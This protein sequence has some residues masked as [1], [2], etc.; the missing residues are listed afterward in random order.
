M[1]WR[2]AAIASAGLLVIAVPPAVRHLRELPPP[3]PPAIRLALTPPAGAELGAGDQILDAALSADD[4][5]LV[6]VATTDGIPRLWRRELATERA[7]P[8][9]GTD[10]AAMP[11]WK[12]TGRVVSFFA[13]GRLRQISLPSG[14]V[15]DLADAP[16]P[17]GAAWL[18]DGSLLFVPDDRGAVRHLHDG[19]VTDATRLRAGER[20]HGFPA[21]ANEGGFTYVATLSTGR[22][23]VRLVADGVERDLTETSSHAQLIGAHLVHVRDGTLIARRFDPERGALDTRSTALAFNVGVASNGQGFFA[24]SPRV[25]AWAAAAPRE[26]ELVWFDFDGRRRGT[27]GEPAD[28]WQIRLSPTDR[29]VAITLLH[30]LLRTLDIFV[31]PL[32]RTAP[33]EQLTLALAAD[34]DPVWSP[35]GDRVLFRSLPRGHP[36]LFARRVHAPESDAEAVFRSELDETPSDWRGGTV[37]FHAPGGAGLEVWALDI[38]RGTRT[39]ATRRGFSTF[40]ARWSP[41]GGR[42]A[43]ASDEGGRPDIYVEPWPPT[44]QRTRVSYAGGTRPEWGRDGRSLFFL[45]DGRMMRTSPD[46]APAQPV[47]EVAAVRDYTLAHRSDRLLAIVPLARGHAPVAGVILD[48]MPPAPPRRPRAGL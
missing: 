35:R 22:R 8:L 30:P 32:T 46:G 48:W 1:I 42:I 47:L 16:A 43:Y 38:A 26:R 11:A 34:S 17:A 18:P 28:Y 9:N 39:A 36:D 5:D 25:V 7:E 27:A 12:T 44:G 41:D 19:V 24:A 14:E 3:P 15:R 13:E 31:L 40:D 2:I 29:D 37:L 45:R 23:V 10:G 33:R 6:F 20:G 4:R 21:A